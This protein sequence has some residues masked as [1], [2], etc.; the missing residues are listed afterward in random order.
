MNGHVTAPVEHNPAVDAMLS[1]LRF[2]IL[3]NVLTFRYLVNYG[4]DLLWYSFFSSI[5]F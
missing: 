5:Y 4:L 3:L 2:E 1:G